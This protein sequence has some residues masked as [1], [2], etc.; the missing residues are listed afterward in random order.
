LGTLADAVDV[1]AC[2]RALDLPH[3]LL[4]DLPLLRFV[5]PDRPKLVAACRDM[6]E[7]LLSQHARARA[8]AGGAAS[9]ARAPLLEAE[10]AAPHAALS[11][12]AV[13][14]L[15]RLLVAV[16][17]TADARAGACALP[18]RFLLVLEHCERL[19]DPESWS[20][21]NALRLVTAGR[22]RGGKRSNSSSHSSGSEAAAASAGVV[23]VSGS[24]EGTV[25]EFAA[26]GAAPKLLLV[27]RPL[28]GLA[29]PAEYLEA[30]AEATRNCTFVEV[31][32]W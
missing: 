16:V 14:R 26:P 1:L 18:F 2:V 31:R 7:Q 30:A 23:S 20:L 19:M 6:Q 4:G 8:A 13:V 29:A 22:R 10:A 15:T 12:A 21:V 17:T 32:A 9:A 25:T 24:L 11:P 28:V 5:F 3:S 27:T